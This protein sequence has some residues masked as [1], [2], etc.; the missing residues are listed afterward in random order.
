MIKY[1]GAKSWIIKEIQ[2]AYHNTN[3]KRFVE[4]FCGSCAVGIGLGV[5]NALMNDIN[6]YLVN[7]FE[8]IK[9]NV[10]FNLNSEDNNSETYYKKREKFNKNIKNKIIGT[11]EMAELFYYLNRTGFNGMCRFNKSGLYNIPIGAYKTVNYKKTFLEYVELFSSWKFTSGDFEKLDIY[12]GDFIYVDSPYDGTFTHY[13][14]SDFT[15]DDQLRLARWI[16]LYDNPIIVSNAATDR[17]IELY[18][19]I[20]LKYKFVDVNRFVAADGSKRG[21]VSEIIAYKNIDDCY[22]TGEN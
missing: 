10:I 18:K 6:P 2:K 12:D 14:T 13:S 4:P 8:Q 3:K 20:G 17:I 5:E 15:W 19:F 11:V 22:F 21:K 16:S 1:P 7:L 9:Y